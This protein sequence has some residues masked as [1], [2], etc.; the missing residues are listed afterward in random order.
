MAS[1]RYRRYKRKYRRYKRKYYKK[2]KY[3]KRKYAFAMFKRVAELATMPVNA[4]GVTNYFP[5]LSD[6][7]GYNDFTQLYDQ[8]KIMKVKFRIERAFTGNDLCAA[9][10]INGNNFTTN[11][12]F[13]IIHDYDG[14]PFVNAEATFFEFQNMKSYPAVGAGP[15]TTTLYPKNI[16]RVALNDQNLAGMA[17]TVVKP[18][19]IDCINANVEHYG[20]RVWYPQLALG[21]DQK[22]RVIATFYIA[23]R[24]TV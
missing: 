13:R 2:N 10:N 3:A 1:R 16:G 22:H 8:Y 5:K 9:A 6:L 14:G 4:A 7:P 12:F 21:N 24:N 17:N 23:C 20:V 18:Q 15:I 19:W 11:K